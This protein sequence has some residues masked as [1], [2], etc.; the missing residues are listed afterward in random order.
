MFKV[1]QLL[2]LTKIGMYVCCI[3]IYIY[4][5]M[6]WK[7]YKSPMFVSRPMKRWLSKSSQHWHSNPL[8]T[9]QCYPSRWTSFSNHCSCHHFDNVTEFGK[10]LLMI[11]KNKASNF[12]TFFCNK[13]KIQNP[14]LGN[15]FSCKCFFVIKY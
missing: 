13:C 12:N 1:F 14:G 2:L 15:Y 9:V 7:E 5:C 3:Y 10:C 11:W 6:Y 4:I 8:H